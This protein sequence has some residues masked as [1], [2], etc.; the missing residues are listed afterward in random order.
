MRRKLSTEVISVVFNV[1]WPV[2][3]AAP[4]PLPFLRDPPA[5]TGGTSVRSRPSTT[6]AANGADAA[7]AIQMLDPRTMGVATAAC[8]AGVSS[9]VAGECVTGDLALVV[10]LISLPLV[11]AGVRRRT[12]N[13]DFK[14]L[15]CLSK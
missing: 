14:L 9:D 7:K 1:I 6:G 11:G 10:Q 3:I 12:C 2:F 5:A 13:P 4:K 15:I 8:Y